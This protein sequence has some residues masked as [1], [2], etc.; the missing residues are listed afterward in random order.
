MKALF[1]AF[2]LICASTHASTIYVN[3]V[4]VGAGGGGGGGGDVFGPGASTAN[5]VALWN[6]TDGTDL[7]NSSVTINGSGYINQG[8]MSGTPFQRAIGI[9][10]FGGA[11]TIGQGGGWM[12]FTSSAANDQSI[13]FV[14]HHSGG[15]HGTRMVIDVDGNVGI[16]NTSPSER[17]HV[18]GNA[19]VDSNLGLG[20]IAPAQKL[21]ITQGNIILGRQ[22]EGDFGRIIGTGSGAGGF[23]LGA[24]GGAWISFHQLSNNNY[25]DFV[26]HEVSV[27]H[28][29]R[30]RL[31]E[32]GKLGIGTTSPRSLLHV[33]GSMSV[34]RTTAAGDYTVLLTDYYVGVTS[35]AAARTITLPAVA[36]A[37]EGKAYVIKDESCAAATNNINIDGNGAETIDTNATV[38]IT[39]NCGVV[40]LISDGANWFTM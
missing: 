40:R 28:A 36:N 24:S 26:T 18:T 3:G 27:S 13:E 37:G 32:T 6:G 25:I 4:P 33:N 31:D 35:T 39:T 38:S 19:R 15:T 7:L 17:L 22:N 29:T 16:A 21:E 34:K 2:L 20:G 23:A 30:M 8:T 9:A 5:A 1:W 14:T 11:F 10:G 12:Q